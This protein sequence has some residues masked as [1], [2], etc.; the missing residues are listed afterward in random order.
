[1]GK[2]K[3]G[4][5][6]SYPWNCVDPMNPVPEVRS[7]GNSILLN[8]SKNHITMLRYFTNNNNNNNIS[9]HFYYYAPDNS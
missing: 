3:C 6:Y 9:L 7:C 1:M 5:T 8:P 4:S 2:W